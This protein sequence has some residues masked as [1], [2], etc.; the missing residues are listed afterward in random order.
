MARRV[1]VADFL[2]RARKRVASGQ[3]GFV[4][5]S[6]VLHLAEH[7]ATE[8]MAQMHQHPQNPAGEPNRKTNQVQKNSDSNVDAISGSC[9]PHI[10]LIAFV[11]H[12]S[13]PATHCSNDIGQLH[14]C[15]LREM[16]ELV[17][18]HTGK[19]L[20]RKTRRQRQPDRQDNIVSRH[21]Q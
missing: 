11:N 18:Q 3:L 21:A 20:H 19:L 17:S 6:I 10:P 13:K 9:Q 12:P 4:G 5:I 7:E 1:E 15:S 16:A 8:E 2:T 14:A